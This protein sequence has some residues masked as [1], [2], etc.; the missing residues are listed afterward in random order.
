VSVGS[1]DQ[2]GGDVSEVDEYVEAE[3]QRLLTEEE[4]L[5]EQGITVN[6]REHFVLLSGEVASPHR[7][8]EI[9][10]LVRQH[11]PNVHFEVDIGVTRVQPPQEAEELP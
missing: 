11:F 10:R 2:Y 7:R 4:R 9:L 1:R 8:D 6:R 3:I 5:A